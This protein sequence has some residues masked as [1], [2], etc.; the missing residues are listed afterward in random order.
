MPTDVENIQQEE[1]NLM[2]IKEEFADLLGH[3]NDPTSLYSRLMSMCQQSVR[4]YERAEAE[5]RLQNTLFDVFKRYAQEKW[6][7]TSF[8]SYCIKAVKIMLNEFKREKS[9]S[10]EY[11]KLVRSLREILESCSLSE[12]FVDFSSEARKFLSRIEEQSGDSIDEGLVLDRLTALIRIGETYQ[13]LDIKIIQVMEDWKRKLQQKIRENSR[14]FVS[15]DSW[16]ND[17]DEARFNPFFNIPDSAPNADEMLVEMQ[18]TNQL[19]D[20]IDKLPP[21]NRE[22]IDLYFF[23]DMGLKEIAKKLGKAI[24]TLSERNKRAILLLRECMT[25]AHEMRGQA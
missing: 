7:I 11:K 25:K 3:Y 13:G 1:S 8:D 20:C 9:R 15:I 14:Q 21:H 22:F 17:E 6:K 23:A 16:T 12:K 5:Q 2:I 19:Y 4:P 10:I 18:T 24:S